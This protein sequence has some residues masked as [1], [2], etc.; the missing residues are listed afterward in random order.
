MVCSRTQACGYDV[1]ETHLTPDNR[2]V[3][4]SSPAGPNIMIT[5]GSRVSLG[6]SERVAV[7]QRSGY[8][9]QGGMSW[10]PCS[11]TSAKR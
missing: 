4:G 11:K 8:D 3:A 7:S 6:A 5:R 1:Q 10:L 2:E 9:G